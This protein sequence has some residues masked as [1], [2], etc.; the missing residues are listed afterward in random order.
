MQCTPEEIERKR[1][2][3]QERLSKKT[4]SPFSHCSAETNLN[5][6]PKRTPLETCR[7]N[8]AKS[9][10]SYTPYTNKYTPYGKPKPVL[11]FYGAKNVVTG[12]CSLISDTRFTVE[13]SSYSAP[14]IDTFKTISSRFY[15][16]KTK[17]WNFHLD[18]YPVFQQKVSSLQPD[19]VIGKLPAYVL[20]CCRQEKSDFS[21]VD[22]SHID[23]ELHNILMPHQIDGVCFGIEKNGR[24]YIADEMGLGK[25]FQALAIANYYK[26]DWPLLIVTTSS[27]KNEWEATIHKY[28]PSVS[29]MQTQ[30][31]VSAK[32]YIGDSTILILSYD[33]MSRAIDKLLERQFKVI[34]MDES[35]MLKNFKTK[36]TKVATTLAKIATRVILL[37]GTPA[38]SR[39]SELYTQLALL[40]EKFFGN[41]FE[42]SKRYCDGKSTNFGWD[43]TGKSNLAELEVIL[44]KK[45]MI[46]RTK[47]DILK[48]L[49]NKQQ[50]IVNLDVKLNQ[51]SEEDRNS[52]KS[53]ALLYNSKKAP[54]DKHAA[55]L[56]FFAETSKI[57]IPSV[58]SFVLQ[59]LEI[60]KKFIVFGH[61]QRMLDAVE[62]IVCS[63]KKKYIR[64][65]GKTTSIQRKYLVDKFQ[66]NDDY[67]CAILSITA[68]NAGITLTAAK[69]V[70]F[71]ELHWNPSILSQ[72]ESRA[73]RI[74]QDGEVVIRYL[75]APGTADDSIWPILQSK[76]KILKE[77]GLCK[78]S[79][80]DLQITNQDLSAKKSVPESPKITS[81]FPPSDKK[82]NGFESDDDFDKFVTHSEI[83]D[84]PEDNNSDIFNDG[85]EE[86]LGNHD[87][88]SGNSSPQ[89]SFLDD[90]L[91]DILCNVELNI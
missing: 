56:T 17:C 63:K 15:D 46:R 82:E 18:D 43:S 32:D 61:H 5:S 68:A 48:C 11:Q 89:V 69:L 79:F 40:D 54:C 42:F 34:I 22:L 27:M 60:E 1:R 66:Y 71:A 28:L 75:L 57:K 74:G 49:P 90:G 85:F 25:T 36:C 2:L 6:P 73:H 26:T 8:T 20:A 23:P 50:E 87:I 41:F 10:S 59:A 80:D 58:C 37:S 38:L 21:N 62:Q 64:I 70:I 44:A 45:F 81:Y 52:L 33:L 3:A 86:I 88:T 65:D 51:L 12:T 4:K 9:P 29:I 19:V 53:L 16:S 35:H 72:A 83:C 76:Q 39:P 47:N 55:L 84:K 78:D 91:D 31:M 30:Y 14:C 7:S 24:C 13:L 77:A 67:V